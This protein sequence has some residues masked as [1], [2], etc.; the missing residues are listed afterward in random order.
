MIFISGIVLAIPT[1]FKRTLWMADTSQA[2]IPLTYSAVVIYLA[3]ILLLALIAV[4]ALRL[5]LEPNYRLNIRVLISSWQAAG[6]LWWIALLGWTLASILWAF[7]PMLTL[8]AAI[9]LALALMMMIIIAGVVVEGQGR[10]L[11]VTMA[12]SGTL[13]ASLALLQITNKG[14]LGLMVLGE[15]TWIAGDPQNFGE[16]TYRA[17]GLAYHPNVLAGYLV[18]ALLA[19]VAAGSAL[20]NRQARWGLGI[21]ALIIAGG[22][23]STLSR[24]AWIAAAMLVAP[25]ILTG[26]SLARMRWQ[27]IRW[28][29]ALLALTTALVIASGFGMSVWERIYT[30]ADRAAVANRLFY[31]YPN[32]A[33]V[34]G[35]SP[36]VGVGAA[37][38]MVV[39]A[40]LL[41]PAPAP[42]LPAASVYWC[43]W[44]E[45]GVPGLALFLIS[46]GQFTPWLLKQGPFQTRLLAWGLAA[47]AV[48]M[49]FNFYLWGDFRTRLLLFWLLG[50]W[51]G[52]R[53]APNAVL[54][55]TPGLAHQ[56]AQFLSGRA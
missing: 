17:S 15:R 35:S 11:F 9:N 14:P 45:L 51:W 33:V 41:S 47:A 19:C 24:T 31:D 55:A 56:G 4:T 48:I 30:L 44:A 8:Y 52:Y 26:A 13:F 34:I 50:V 29:V 39:M 2:A 18:I 23:A 38:L 3:D 42:L 1:T 54:M 20:K 12:I 22:L 53:L 5:F 36:L 7:E 27:I 32:T 10:L 46:F 40:K 43:L 6:G 49:G 37:N 16:T 28:V 25:I 21:A